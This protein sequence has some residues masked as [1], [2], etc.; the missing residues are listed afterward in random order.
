M[1][2]FLR[3]Q[4]DHTLCFCDGAIWAL[5]WTT[6]RWSI[7]SIENE[8]VCDLFQNQHIDLFHEYGHNSNFSGIEKHLQRRHARL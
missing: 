5:S 2:N 7:V 1:T 8:E 6:L 3:F 4:E